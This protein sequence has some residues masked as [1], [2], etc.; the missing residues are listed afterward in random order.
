MEIERLYYF[1]KEEKNTLVSL[2]INILVC[3][4]IVVFSS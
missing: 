1:S 3:K 4:M 2:F